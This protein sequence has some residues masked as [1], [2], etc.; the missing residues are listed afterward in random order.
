[1]R[2]ALTIAG[3]DSIGGAGIQADIKA[4]GSL[5]VHAACV[6]TAVTAQNT[7]EVAE[8]FPVP[9]EIIEAQYRS[10]TNDLKINAV[11]TGMLYS[12][13]TAKLV[14]EFLEDDDMPL[15]IDP[16][17]TAGVGGSLAERGLADS[18]RSHLMPLCELITPNKYEAEILAGIKINNEY[19]ATLACELIGKDGSSVY[20]KGGHMDT[21]KVIDYLYLNSQIKKFE[22][23]RLDRSGHG[24]GCT[25]S[26]FITANC[27]KG[28]DIASAVMKSRELIQRSIATQYSIGKGDYV[29]NTMVRSECPAPSNSTIDELE[30]IS[31]KML[32]TLPSKFVPK[33]GLNMA[34]ATPGAK[35]PEDIAAVS[36]GITL[37]N[38]NLKKGG[39]VRFGAA[40]QLSYM[41]LGAM[42]ADP[43]IRSVMSIKYSSD[44]A[45][46]LE[47]FGYS[48]GRFDRRSDR[49]VDSMMADVIKKTGRVPDA[50]IDAGN[51]NER[52]IRIFGKDPKD[53]LGKAETIF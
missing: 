17:L 13:N 51:G 18:I 42:K 25:L 49:S 48:I 46:I 1:M 12:P 23:P 31:S 39:P 9:E 50:I 52:L 7:Y 15:I 34:Y 40:G 38:G 8:I 35:G 6:I 4:M 28:M 47:E 11:K 2:T 36:G 27:A 20:L 26:S 19:D 14:A 45:D 43:E 30:S 33:S 21:R 37:F 44:T 29:V 16:V 3:S 24:S 53:V 32:E 5:D 41:L 10:V 22:Y